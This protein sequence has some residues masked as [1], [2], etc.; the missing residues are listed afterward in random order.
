MNSR[1]VAVRLLPWTT[2]EGKPCYLLGGGSGRVSRMA[3]DVETMQLDMAVELLDHA[4]DMLADARVT[5]EQLRFLA[6]RMTESLLD[7]LRVAESRGAR[8][9]TPGPEPVHDTGEENEEAEPVGD[10]APLPS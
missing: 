10:A 8:L 6:T 3:D 2:P 4:A 5:P 9:L 7:V 1:P